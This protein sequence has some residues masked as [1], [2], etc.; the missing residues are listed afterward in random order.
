LPDRTA[1][2]FKRP[3][4]QEADARIRTAGPFITRVDRRGQ[5]VPASPSRPCRKAKSAD[6]EGQRGA[7]GYMTVF[8]WCSGGR[9]HRSGLR[10]GRDA[11]V[12][13]LRH[14]PQRRHDG[15]PRL[16]PRRLLPRTG[17]PLVLATAIERSAPFPGHSR[18]G[19]WR[20]MLLAKSGVS[21]RLWATVLGRREARKRSNG[22]PCFA[23]KSRSSH[24][25]EL[26]TVFVSS[27]AS[28]LAS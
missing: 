12:R 17:R 15:G 18:A 27:H 11:L 7:L 9:R 25:V 21:W 28:R 5:P 26:W 1:A 8:G 20:S 16:R 2:S 3:A 19:A 22:R 6:S 14:G 24:G 10:T 13:R 4:D 23:R